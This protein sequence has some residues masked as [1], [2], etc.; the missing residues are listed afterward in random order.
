MCDSA[1]VTQL[2]GEETRLWAGTVCVGR[3]R[4]SVPLSI[5]CYQL[6]HSM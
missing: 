3:L 5:S 6:M 2:D 1:G 4:C